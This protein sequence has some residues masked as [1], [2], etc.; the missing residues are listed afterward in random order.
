MRKFGYAGI[1]VAIAVAVTLSVT[2]GTKAATVTTTQDAYAGEGGGWP[3]YSDSDTRVMVGKSGDDKV[4]GGW[5]FTGLDIPADAIITAAY[6]ELVQQEWGFL[7]ESSF[8]FE[9]V[10]DAE[11]FSEESTPLDRWD[12]RTVAQAPWIWTQV[13]PGAVIRSP[14]L[15]D[16]VQELVDNYGSLESVVLI[17]APADSTPPGQYHQWGSMESGQGT[18]LVIEYT[19]GDGSGDTVPT[20]TPTGAGSPFP[21]NAEK[22]FTVPDDVV[23]FNAWASADGNNGTA[24]FDIVGFDRG[25]SYDST[26]G[27]F[28]APQPG[29]YEFTW[30]TPTSVPSLVVNGVDHHRL[31]TLGSV[32]VELEVGDEVMVTTTAGYRAQAENRNA[33][34]TGYLVRQYGA[35]SPAVTP[36]P[37]PSVTPTP[38][39]TPGGDV[40]PPV[41]TAMAISPSIV[42]AS[43][44]PQVVTFTLNT[45]DDL[46]GV[47][48][49]NIFIRS[50]SGAINGTGN[51]TLVSG[52]ELVGTYE[53]QFNIPQYSP[54]GTWEVKEIQ[55][56]DNVGNM[57]KYVDRDLVQ[58]LGAQ[59]Y[60]AYLQDAGL[61]NEFTVE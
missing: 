33:F 58:S 26:T 4:Y 35:A 25:D 42:P 3:G 17:E 2:N 38:V 47:K 39:G 28:T 57:R 37:A 48:Y 29:L 13:T 15:V 43:S 32:L 22:N 19:N 1:I 46:S 55:V 50:A 11:P 40:T 45:N 53:I 52:D 24:I 49:L 21:S 14:S 18:R 36:T 23:A 60:S 8:V 51:A 59:I 56:F 10:K 27:I 61:A 34:F 20:V 6:V 7:F 54:T 41:V 5:R 16:G 12:N 9:N 31:G 30:G 44:G